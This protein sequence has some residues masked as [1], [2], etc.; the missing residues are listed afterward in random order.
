MSNPPIQD[1][2]AGLVAAGTSTARPSGAAPAL[3]RR[4]RV[5]RRVR[6]LASGASAVRCGGGGAPGGSEADV[7]DVGGLGWPQK[8]GEFAKDEDSRVSRV[9]D[10]FCIYKTIQGVTR[11]DFTRHAKRS[12]L[13]IQV[14]PAGHSG[15]GG[16]LPGASSFGAER[17]LQ[18]PAMC[19]TPVGG[20]APGGWDQMC[21]VERPRLGG[22]A[23]GFNIHEIVGK[24]WIRGNFLNFLIP[25]PWLI[26]AQIFWGCLM[27]ILRPAQM[28]ER[29]WK[30]ANA[31]LGWS[32]SIAGNS[33]SSY[34]RFSSNDFTVAVH[35]T[36]TY[37]TTIF[38]ARR[39]VEDGARKGVILCNTVSICTKNSTSM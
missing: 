26:S 18:P 6:R 25:G 21:C 27:P 2:V 16:G 7:G 22:R 17:L 20:C 38:W 39:H 12:Q 15:D 14:L 9:F 32:S 4:R 13:H 24:S 37:W 33:S 3:R 23:E 34:G 36:W 1:H 28:L 5:R 35:M 31:R 29:L 19:G 8:N 11:V 30:N 10:G